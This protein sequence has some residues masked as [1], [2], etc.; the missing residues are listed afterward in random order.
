MKDGWWINYQTRRFTGL[1]CP[2]MEHETVLRSPDDQDWLGIPP[3]VAK[4]FIRFSPKADRIRLLRYA[5]KQ[6]PLMRIRGYG[7]RVAFQYW[8]PSGDIEPYA[9][10]DKWISRWGGLRLLLVVTNLATKRTEQVSASDW[11]DFLKRQPTSPAGVLNQRFQNRHAK[12]PIK[13]ALFDKPKGVKRNVRL[14]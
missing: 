10:I 2:G 13:T 1:Y 7:V 9:M 8:S 11:A 3:A 14:I 12:S 4:S 6:V 5:M